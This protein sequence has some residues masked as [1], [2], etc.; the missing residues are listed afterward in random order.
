MTPEK[1]VINFYLLCNKLKNII[2]T[3]WVNWHV[4]RDRLESVAEHIYS[5]QMLAIAINSEYKYDIDIQK[6]IYML[7]VHEMEE[8][9][10]G[11]YTQFDISREEKLK[12]GH[13]AIEKILSEL[14]DKDYIKQMILEFDERKTNEAFFAYQV[15]KL[16]CDLQCKLYDEEGCIQVDLEKDRKNI[17]NDIALKKLEEGCSLSEM[18]MT[19]GR[20][21][22]NYDENFLKISEYAQNNG[23][24]HSKQD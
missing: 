15:D 1:R 23:I 13:E 8:I 5:T 20:I 14:A 2:R 22:Y 3:G 16:E 17:H 7:A 9:M 19:F 4:D 18:W 6:V 12:L 10:I 21:R 11:D 24:L